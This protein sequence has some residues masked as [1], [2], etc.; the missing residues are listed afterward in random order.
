MVLCL[1]TGYLLPGEKTIPDQIADG[2]KPYYD[3]LEMADKAWADGRID[4]TE[5]E[6]LL[7]SLL[8]R[9]L[10]GVFDD[11]MGGRIDG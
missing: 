4:L 11:V 7:S 3:A 9:Q 10:I 1:R 8:A 2:R 6:T 5:M